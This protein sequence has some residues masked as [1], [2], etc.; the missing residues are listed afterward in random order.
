MGVVCCARAGL[1][2]APSGLDHANDRGTR[3]PAVNVRFAPRAERSAGLVRD[4]VMTYTGTGPGLV[5]VTLPSP[6]GSAPGPCARAPFDFHAALPL[7]LG[8]RHASR[9]GDEET[10]GA[11]TRE[12]N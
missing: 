9:P 5:A 1:K 8:D 10:C 12:T 11:M 4:R 6:V 3:D 2:P 7:E